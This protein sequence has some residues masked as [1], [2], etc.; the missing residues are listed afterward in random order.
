[1][2]EVTHFNNFNLIRLIG[3]FLV[4]FTHSYG[5]L[6]KG[7]Q[8]PLIHLQETRLILGNLGLYAFFTISGFLIYKSLINSP[9]YLNYLWKR[10]LRIIPGLAVVNLACIVLGLFITKLS[11]I[12]YLSIHIPGAIFSSI[13]PL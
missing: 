4:L 5:V 1:M 2:P 3:A 7:L 11:L 8:Q 12:Q 6:D 10:F 13:I 9:T